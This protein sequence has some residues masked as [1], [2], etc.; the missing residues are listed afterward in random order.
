MKMGNRTSFKK[1]HKKIGGFIKD[2]KHSQKSKELISNSLLGKTG[3]NSR[4]WKGDDAGYVAI[5]LWLYKKLTK[6]GK[7]NNPICNYR[8]PKRTE[9]A[10]ISRL[11]RRNICDYIELCPS[12]HRKYDINKLSIQELYGKEAV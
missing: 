9:W 3:T 10:S 7:C 12:C 5:H 8:N 4:R 11:N 1:G 6:T 2:S